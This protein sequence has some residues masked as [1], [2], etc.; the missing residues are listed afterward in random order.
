MKLKKQLNKISIGTNR[1]VPSSQ[2][3]PIFKT[4][5]LQA[6]LILGVGRFKAIPIKDFLS[7]IRKWLTEKLKLDWVEIGYWRLFWKGGEFWFIVT[8][9]RRRFPS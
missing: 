4:I 9:Q 2:L 6:E 3:S 8:M 7:L 5:I 1:I